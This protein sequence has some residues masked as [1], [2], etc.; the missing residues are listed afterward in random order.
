MTV[1]IDPYDYLNTSSDYFNRKRNPVD[2]AESGDTTYI[3]FYS[4]D[5]GPVHRITKADGVT[6]M[7]WA[8]GSWA[9]RA[10]LSYATDLNTPLTVTEF[11]R[12]VT[13]SA[14]LHVRS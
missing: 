4:S 9:N 11:F 14:S 5:V 1:T 13:V 6:S 10:S 3:R 2:V 8:Y 12:T 7:R